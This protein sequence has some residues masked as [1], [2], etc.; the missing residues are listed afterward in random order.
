MNLLD[1]FLLIPLLWGAIRG[2]SKGFIREITTLAGLVA[3]IFVSVIV[4]DTAA[5]VLAA[6]I[7]WNPIPV[8]ILAF[9]ITFVLVFMLFSLLGRLLEK[10]FRAFFLNPVNRMAGLIFGVLKYAFFIS[11]L[12][13][14]FTYFEQFY[15]L[16]PAETKEN[17]F[18][19]TL[20][21]PLAPMVIPAKDLIT[22]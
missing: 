11:L 13:V 12:F 10:I 6:L 5:R 4:A 3:G 17:S 16:I 21:Q 14:F 9:A 18:L 20:I 22:W 15:V 8:L 19:Y 2:F 1:I 7:N